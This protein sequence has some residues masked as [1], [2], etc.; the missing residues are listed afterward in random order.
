FTTHKL[1]GSGGTSTVP[2]SIDPFFFRVAEEV[3]KSPFGPQ[4]SDACTVTLPDIRPEC[5]SPAAPAWLPYSQCVFWYETRF[6]GQFPLISKVV[7]QHCAKLLGRQQGPLL[8]TTTL[9][10]GETLKLYHSDRYRRTR[11]VKDAYSV[12]TSWRLYVSA[13]HRS[14][15]VES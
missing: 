8:Y 5:V 9:L 13:A 3:P 11:A 1:I 14:R 12:H 10:P 15:S 4:P 7:Y 6:L 2:I